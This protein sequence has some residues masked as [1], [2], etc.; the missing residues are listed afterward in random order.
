MRKGI[1]LLEMITVLAIIGIIVAVVA[2]KASQF[3]PGIQLSGSARTLVSNL[4]EAQERAVTEQNQHLIRFFPE[5]I[6]PN[7]QL[8]RI[9][10]SVE[11][12]PIEELI[13]QVDLPN[14]QTITIDET[15]F[16]EVTASYQVIFSADGGPSASGNIILS[17]GSSQ[18][19]INVSPAGYIKI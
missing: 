14:G 7:Y 11:E 5:A 10:Y 12:L 9:Y 3:L 1:S 19:I 17:N 2:P 15:F 4:R 8:I 16:D 6:P 13:K 18:K